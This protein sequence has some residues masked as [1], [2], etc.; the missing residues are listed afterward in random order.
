MYPELT[1]Y[2]IQYYS[3]LMTH[4]EK[5]THLNIIY[6]EKSESNIDRRD[7]FTQK[8]WIVHTPEYDDLLKEGYDA[9][10]EKVAERILRENEKE[11]VLNLCP[12]CQKLARTPLAKQCR[13]CFHSWH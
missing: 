6:L 12:K 13:F 10:F 7:L 4:N 8:G 9:F 3:Y 5:Q 11:V 1:D 2:I